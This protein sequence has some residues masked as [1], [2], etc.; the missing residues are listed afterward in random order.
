MHN[1]QF[2]ESLKYY[3]KFIELSDASDR[4]WTYWREILGV[5]YVYYRNGYKK[6]ADYYFDETIN[7][8][9]QVIKINRQSRL[10]TAYYVLA[11]V[12]AIRGEKDKAYE[13]LRGFNLLPILGSRVMYLKNDPWW[14]NIKNEPEFQQS[15]REWVLKYQAEHERVRKWLEE[16]DML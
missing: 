8:Y 9:E 4:G 10:M 12:Y 6:E 7:F 14:D 3:E 1:G 5:A 15:V 16:N 2:K 13:N 11:A